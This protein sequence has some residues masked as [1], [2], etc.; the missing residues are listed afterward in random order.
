LIVYGPESLHNGQSGIRVCGQ[1]GEDWSIERG[2]FY[3]RESPSAGS[4]PESDD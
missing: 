1:F 4:E 3:W 2:E